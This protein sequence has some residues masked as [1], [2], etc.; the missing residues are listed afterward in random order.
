LESPFDIEQDLY[1]EWAGLL[2]EHV[3]PQMMICGHMHKAYVSHIGDETDHLGQ[4][5]A[6]VVA[7]ETAGKN[8]EIPYVGGAF[9]LYP[10]RCE[11]KFTEN[12]GKIKSEETLIFS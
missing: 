4:P 3:H 12:T 5:C 8:Q 2:R 1:R 9:V 7:S 6:V 10:D 11:V